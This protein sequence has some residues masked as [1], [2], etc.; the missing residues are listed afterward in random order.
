MKGELIIIAI[1]IF[2]YIRIWYL[3][4]KKRPKL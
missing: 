3:E 2:L 1:G 4:S